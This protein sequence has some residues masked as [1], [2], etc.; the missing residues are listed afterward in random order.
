M[1]FEE[2]CF[3]K[4]TELHI[5]TGTPPLIQFTPRITRNQ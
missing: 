2:L 1:L 4:V 3:Y 5:F